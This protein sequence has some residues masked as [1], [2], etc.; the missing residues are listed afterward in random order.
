M[1]DVQ[2]PDPRATVRRI[3]ELLNRSGLSRREFLAPEDLACRAG[4]TVA[5]VEALLEGE[6]LPVKSTGTYAVDRI[7]QLMERGYQMG[8]G[9]FRPYTLTD[10]ASTIG[11]SP[12]GLKKALDKGS[13]TNADYLKAAA[14]FF[15]VTLEYLTDSPAEAL[16]RVLQQIHMELLEKAVSVQERSPDLERLS[17]KYGVVAMAARGDANATA[18]L[19]VFEGVL[20]AAADERAAERRQEN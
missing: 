8:D 10:V 19:G 12:T 3:E 7:R 15:G 2:T 16:E 13:W 9:D 4:L 14:K 11:I 18:L 5:E 17:A 20:Q 6:D 1:N